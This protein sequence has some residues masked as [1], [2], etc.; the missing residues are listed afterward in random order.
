MKTIDVIN[1]IA[2]KIGELEINF[3]FNNKT[4]FLQV[5]GTTETLNRYYG[6]YEGL[7]MLYEEL[8]DSTWVTNPS[9]NLIRLK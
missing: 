8:T 2:S 4:G 1:E 6:Q 5:Q 7:V 3:G 9:H